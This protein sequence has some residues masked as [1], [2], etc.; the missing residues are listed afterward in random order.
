MGHLLK[1]E[2]SEGSHHNCLY[3]EIN[4]E[5]LLVLSTGIGLFFAIIRKSR[6]EDDDTADYLVGGRSVR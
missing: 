6:N 5:S 4:L 2:L 3:K 1:I